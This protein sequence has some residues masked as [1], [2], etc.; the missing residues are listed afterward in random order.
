MRSNLAS[1]RQNAPPLID[2][3]T[4][5]DILGAHESILTFK[6]KWKFDPMAVAVRSARETSASRKPPRKPQTLAEQAYDLIKDKLVSGQYIPGQ[7]LQEST[8]CKDLQMG[9][10][11]VHQALHQ[12]QQE[13]LLEII[14]RKGIFIKVETPSEVFIALEVRGLLEPHCAGQCAERA[15][16]EDIAHF[17]SL[18]KQDAKL[19][20]PHDKIKLMELD[21][22]FHSEIAR[23]AGNS[24]IVDILRP[25]HERMSRMIWSLPHWQ[26][27]DFDLTGEEHTRILSAIEAG[28]SESASLR[29]KEHIASLRQ[30]ILAVR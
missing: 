16:S 26:L 4:T 8:I 10:T 5:V 7:F 21:R 22:M 11:P 20:G 28:D 24:L 13:A 19:R 2:S 18:L 15:T 1:D 27:N 29:M 9:R 3:V 14:P 6:W 30:R 17:K 23:V 12:L 25:I